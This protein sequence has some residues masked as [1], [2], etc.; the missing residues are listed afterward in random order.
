MKTYKVTVGSNGTIRWYNEDGQLH[1]ED[2]PAYEEAS[3]SKQWW[4]NNQLHREDGPAVELANGNKFW[5]LNGQRLT[6]KEFNQRT[7]SHQEM[8]VF[9]ENKDNINETWYRMKVLAGIIK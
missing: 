7:Q 9:R 3:G 8:T 1:R 4:I 6:E 5:Y 2:G